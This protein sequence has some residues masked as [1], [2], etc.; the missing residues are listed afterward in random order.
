MTVEDKSWSRR[1]FI[2]IS[3]AA[4]V[5]AVVSPIER[6]ARAAGTSASKDTSASANATAR[7]IPKRPFGNSGVDV[8]ILTLGGSMSFMSRQLLLRQAF[9]TGI[10]AWDTS[11]GYIGGK[12]EKGIGKYFA[13]YPDHRQN[14]FLI[15]KTSA[16]DPGE[17]TQSLNRSLK[18]MQT[19]HIDLYLIQAVSDVKKQ[20]NKSIQAWADGVKA[21]GLIRFFGFSTHKNM[22]NCLAEGARLSCINGIMATYNYRVMHRRHMKKAVQACV[23]AGIGI[24]SMK[25]Q[26]ALL[27]HI[28]SDLG[29]ETDTALKLK[30]QFM[31]KGFTAEQ[32]KLKSVWENP[33][34]ASICSHMPNMSI[35][36]ANVAAARQKTALSFSDKQL[37]A[38]YSRE[39]S[40]AYCTGCAKICEP[41]VGYA[42]P[43]SDIL[44]Y[45][46]YYGGYRDQQ[47]AIRLFSELPIDTRQCMGQV[48]Y[49]KAEQRCPQNL[50]IARL[51]HTAVDLLA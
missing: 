24:I 37:L 39:T 26:A 8:S 9:K 31:D 18:R 27:G 17:L 50:P 15:T 51:M 30:Q 7:I 25:T 48:D 41:A 34:I 28:F 36:Q 4:S 38:Q 44:R 21:K 13:K 23:D 49:A 45:L 33:S 35:L 1:D 12:S 22:E 29:R 20:I 11:S 3:G 10:T 32:A 47:R 46:M 6:L 14:I 42:I 2:K 43:I 40:R 5:G 19:D 16:S